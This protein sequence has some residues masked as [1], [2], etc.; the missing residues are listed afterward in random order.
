[1]TRSGKNWIKKKKKKGTLNLWLTESLEGTLKSPKSLKIGHFALVFVTCI[2]RNI[3][4]FV[5]LN[6]GK[7]FQKT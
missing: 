2:L 7:K 6:S 4:D 3:A 1:M 5:E